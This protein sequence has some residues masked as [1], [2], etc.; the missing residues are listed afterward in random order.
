MT[1]K[2]VA[3]RGAVFNSLEK[4]VGK[5]LKPNWI[6]GESYHLSLANISAVLNDV[7]K[8]LGHQ[9]R[10]HFDDAFA[11]NALKLDADE[12]TAKVYEQIT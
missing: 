7:S 3:V 4:L 11:S 5:P 6:L 1:A 10:F 9:Y 8:T 2:L 12:L